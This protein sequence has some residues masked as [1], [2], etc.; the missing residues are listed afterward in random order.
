MPKTGQMTGHDRSDLK[1]RL[2][3][4]YQCLQ[5]SRQRQTKRPYSLNSFLTLT[6]IKTMFWYPQIDWHDWNC[7][8]FAYYNLYLELWSWPWFKV[9]NHYA[10]SPS[11]KSTLMV[12]AAGRRCPEL[13]LKWCLEL[14]LFCFRIRERKRVILSIIFHPE[15]RLTDIKRYWTIAPRLLGNAMHT[16][17]QGWFDEY[18]IEKGFRQYWKIHKRW[19]SVIKAE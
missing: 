11:Q 16:Y 3:K 9:W 1:P 19:K 7:I 17:M 15:C 2:S 5:I 4:S 13:Q 12:V 10:S 8:N 14:L 18:K 6:L